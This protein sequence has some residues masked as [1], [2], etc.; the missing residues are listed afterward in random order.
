MPKSRKTHLLFEN[1]SK[2]TLVGSTGKLTHVNAAKCCYTQC[3]RAAEPTNFNTSR[4]TTDFGETLLK[5]ACAREKKS[6]CPQWR[7][8]FKFVRKRLTRKGTHLPRGGIPF[9]SINYGALYD[10]DGGAIRYDMGHDRVRPVDL[11]RPGPDSGLLEEEPVGD[12]SL[13]R[14][15]IH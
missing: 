5:N 11:V 1:V 14:L 13:A 15:R 4:P 3:C 12:P 6:I 7:P 9:H 10:I 2:S 8:I